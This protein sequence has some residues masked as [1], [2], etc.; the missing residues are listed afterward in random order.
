MNTHSVQQKAFTYQEE[1]FS[2]RE[3]WNRLLA[4]LPDIV[5][6]FSAN[7]NPFPVEYL[8]EENEEEPHEKGVQLHNQLYTASQLMSNLASANGASLPHAFDPNRVEFAGK[9][10]LISL[11]RRIANL[12]FSKNTLDILRDNPKEMAKALH[13]SILRIINLPRVPYE[14][15]GDLE[16]QDLMK[17]TIAPYLTN[18]QPNRSLTDGLGT[19][20]EDPVDGL[21]E[22]QTFRIMLSSISQ[23]PAD[24]SFTLE[25]NF[26][27][28]TEQLP[29]IDL[30][31]KKRV[32]YQ[33]AEMLVLPFKLRADHPHPP[34]RPIPRAKIQVTIQETENLTVLLEKEYRVKEVFLNTAI[35]SI[36]ISPEECE[37]LPLNQDLKVEIVFRYPGREGAVYGTLKNQYITLVADKVFDR[38]GAT[39]KEALPL[40]DVVEHRNYWHKIWRGGYNEGLPWTLKAD[41]KYYMILG[42]DQD[43]AARLE[44]RLKIAEEFSSE[45]DF[46]DEQFSYK[47]KLKTG[48]ELT[49]AML[50]DLL[51]E[52]GYDSISHAQLSALTCQAF[53]SQ[54]NRV[55]HTQLSLQAESGQ[56]ISVWVYPEVDYQEVFLLKMGQ[57][58]PYGLVM[59]MSEE[60][61]VF[62]QAVNVHFIATQHEG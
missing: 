40:N 44:T 29:K 26:H 21:F 58:N 52:E 13:D 6:T 7:F 60:K 39:V 33:H 22:D 47:A 20:M 54:M 9:N 11:L 53:Q 8:Q 42:I 46:S 14:L 10:A 28:Y 34:K 12:T 35:H 18:Y 19:M 4:V 16:T 1:T 48:L 30:Q 61:I 24:K 32:V 36:V 50:N 3:F 55:A 49:P 31:G 43:Q 17:A 23:V 41:V 15:S 2:E 25:N 56:Q 38:V 5:E 59:D 27:I 37:K 45:E 51:H 62:P 57:V